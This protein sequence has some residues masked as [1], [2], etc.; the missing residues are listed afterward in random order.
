MR[1]LVDGAREQIATL[2]RNHTAGTTTAELRT[3]LQ[4]LD[5]LRVVFLEEPDDSVEHLS[6]YYGA[7]TAGITAGLSLAKAWGSA[8]AS[9]LFSCFPSA[10]VLSHLKV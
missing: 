2:L 10:S 9:G 4:R 6:R 3:V 8:R 1:A 5:G 7:S